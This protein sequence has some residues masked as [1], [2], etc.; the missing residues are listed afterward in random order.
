M[1]TPR[2]FLLTIALVFACAIQHAVA[3]STARRIEL[4]GQASLLR[5]SDF[6]TTQGGIGGRVTLDVTN[7]LAADAEFQFFPS[8]NIVLPI[9]GVGPTALPLALVAHYRRRTD[10][11]VGVKV[12]TRASKFGVYAK[13]RPGFTYLFDR[14][15]ECLGVECARI[16]MLLARDEY[17][18]EF[19]LD[20]GGGVEF[21]PTARTVARVEFGDTMIR[22][23]SFAPPCWA[24]RCTSHNF[25]TRI[26]GGVRF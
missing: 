17:K 21:Y 24:D 11:F 5:L 12:G 13:V 22:H 19:A 9:G 16:L 6:D 10:G 4:S 26:G 2:V 7:W 20:L 14:G 23:R 18:P 8:D 25:S 3:Q 1:K 15:T